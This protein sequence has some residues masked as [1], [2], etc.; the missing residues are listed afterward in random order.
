M[1]KLIIALI[2]VIVTV[3]GKAQNVN[4]GDMEI[5][6]NTPTSEP[7]GWFTNNTYLP[8]QYIHV[9][10]V[11][12]SSGSAARIATSGSYYVPGVIITPLSDP[13][14]GE[15]GIPY[16]GT[17][18]PTHFKGTYRYSVAMGDSAIVLLMLKKMAQ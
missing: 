8:S 9:T 5:W 12:G 13:S 1:N 2:L 16:T 11:N 4:N 17:G 14:T 18:I 15:G 10:Q 6:I 3:T 7:N